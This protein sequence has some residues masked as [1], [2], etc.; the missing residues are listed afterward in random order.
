MTYY[1]YR[2]WDPR[3]PKEHPMLLP[4]GNGRLIYVGK[5]KK[6]RI[7]DHEK[8]ARYLKN[9]KA[10][11]Y[12]GQHLYNKII[13]IL[14][15]GLEVEKEI[16]AYFETEKEALEYENKL[17]REYGIENLCNAREGGKGGSLSDETKRKISEVLKGK[18]RA[19]NGF[20]VKYDWGMVHFIR[21]Y[22]KYGYTMN[23][24]SIM[25]NIPKPTIKNIV[26][27]ESWYEKEY[28]PHKDKNPPPP[29]YLRP[30][31]KDY[32]KYRVIINEYLYDGMTKKDLVKKYGCANYVLKTDLFK[33]I[34]NYFYTS[35]R[36]RIIKRNQIIPPDIIQEFVEELNHYPIIEEYKELFERSKEVLSKYYIFEGLKK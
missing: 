27:N 7:F 14:N 6:R 23:E 33:T 21:E 8:I 1:V 15:E 31:H 28:D 18:H 16:L 5:G 26:L 17:T 19:E 13:K 4:D 32:I 24:L 11:K 29:T 12:K 25:T 22:W 34:E 35:G 9:G 36:V 10:Q 3:K 2:L 30:N 20:N